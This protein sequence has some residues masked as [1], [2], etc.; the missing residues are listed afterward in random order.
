VRNKIDRRY[1]N[2]AGLEGVCGANS[3]YPHLRYA[4]VENLV[5]SYLVILAG[6]G[7]KK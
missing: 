6:H 3:L 5:V 2:D 7:T 4:W 1:F